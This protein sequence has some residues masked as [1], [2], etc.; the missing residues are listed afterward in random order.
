MKII[1]ITGGVGA[2]KSTILDYLE[3]RYDAYILKSDEAAMRIQLPGG[4]IYEDVSS[5]L[6]EYPTGQA[7]LNDDGSLYRPEVAQRM[8]A[9]PELRARMN[10]IVHPA[11]KEDILAA[12]ERESASGRAYFVLEAALLIECGYNDVVD[13][14]WYIYCDESVRRER[15]KASRGYSDD[16]IDNIMASQLSDAQFRDGSDVVIDNSG[17]PEETYR[18]IDVAMQRFH[19][20]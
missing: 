19:M 4:A 2:G 5:L 15:L 12:M 10:A 13:T 14:M 9:H 16:K 17:A 7:L 20:A 11:V 1:G 6:E 18:Q 3:S 8:F